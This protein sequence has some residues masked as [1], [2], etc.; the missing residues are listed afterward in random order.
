MRLTR[1]RGTRSMPSWLPWLA[2]ALAFS[3][4]VAGIVSDA[5]IERIQWGAVAGVVLLVVAGWREAAPTA[6]SSARR[7]AGGLALVVGGVA[8]LLAGLAVD[9]AFV[10]RAGFPLVVIGLA[11]WLGRPSLAVAALSL[12]AVPIPTT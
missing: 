4:V 3:P 7:T 10:A 6:A 12:F 5:R 11:V 9:T 2:V 1:G 8:L